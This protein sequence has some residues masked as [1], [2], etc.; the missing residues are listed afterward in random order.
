MREAYAAW[1]EASF[2]RWKSMHREDVVV[3]PPEAFPEGDPT[4]DREA[5]FAQAMRLTD[6]W[7]EQR[8]DLEEIH[9][10]PG[11]RVLSLFRWVTKGKDCGISLDT[12]MAS[13]T[14]VQ[15]GRIARLEFY[16]DREEARRKAG[17][18]E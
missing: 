8:I 10:V 15:G 16:M 6:S 7:E 3:I 9:D 2:E 12:P 1:N 4:E 5:W 17:L 14:T 18:T 11:D 13:I